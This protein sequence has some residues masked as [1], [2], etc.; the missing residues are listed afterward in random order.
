MLIKET[1]IEKN[2]AVQNPETENPSTILAA[3]NINSALI[4]KE[5]NPKVIIVIGKVR[6]KIIGLIKTFI[7]PRTTARITAPKRVTVTPGSR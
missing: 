2:N 6:I 5:N 7:I 4:T 3:S 1:I